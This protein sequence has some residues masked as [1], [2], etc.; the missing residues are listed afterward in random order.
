M[1]AFDPTT[2]TW[3]TVS[4]LQVPR[5]LLGAA[6]GGDGRLYAMGGYNFVDAVDVTEAWAPSY[7]S[8]AF[9]P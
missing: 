7:T 8:R 3:A 2:G 5:E 6:L 9:W 4:T 1:Q